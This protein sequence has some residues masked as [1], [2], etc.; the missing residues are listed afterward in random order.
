MITAHHLVFGRKAIV[1][2]E[3]LILDLPLQNSFVDAT[4]KNTIIAGGTSNLP[5]FTLEGSEYAATFNGSQSLKTNANFV[6]GKDKVSISFWMK[7]TQTSKSYIIELSQNVN[8]YDNT[9][10]LIM[11]DITSNPNCLQIADHGTASNYNMGW[12]PSNI[13]SSW[14]HVVIIIDRTLNSS[15]NKIYI[16]GVF[17]YNATSAYQSDLSG[18]FANNPLFF[19]QRGGSSYGFIGQMKFLKIFNYPLSPTEITNLFN[20]TM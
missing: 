16:N 5:T 19:G 4:G 9:F 17:N 12:T 8:T 10:A 2:N 3:G 6:I 15:Q 1:K 11:N 18:L 7:T 13:L 20:K 14:T